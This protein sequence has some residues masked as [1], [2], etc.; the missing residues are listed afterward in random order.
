MQIHIRKYTLVA[1]LAGIDMY[2]LR[3]NMAQK[4]HM[5]I[6]SFFSSKGCAYGFMGHGTNKEVQSNWHI[7][8]HRN[9]STIATLDP[10]PKL[11]LAL[12][13]DLKVKVFTTACTIGR[14]LSSSLGQ[15]IP[16]LTSFCILTQSLE[17]VGMEKDS[18]PAAT[19]NPPAT[20][21][22]FD[23]LVSY[24]NELSLAVNTFKPV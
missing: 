24:Q 16:T 20:R 18:W 9:F 7:I 13:I 21:I 23:T 22:K 14:W 5:A 11:Q 19:T 4:K 17:A 8:V 1:K 6:F 3:R 2:K 12:Q 10:F 15:Q